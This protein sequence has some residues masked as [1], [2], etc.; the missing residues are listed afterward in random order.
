MVDIHSIRYIH[1][2]AHIMAIKGLHSPFFG[3]SPGD[4]DAKSSYIY[5]SLPKFQVTVRKLGHP[6][7]GSFLSLPATVI[8]QSSEATPGK[9]MQ[10]YQV[11]FADKKSDGCTHKSFTW[12]LLA[13]LY[14]I[15]EVFYMALCMLTS[16]LEPSE[17][18]FERPM[19]RPGP[20]FPWMRTEMRCRRPRRR[21]RKRRSRCRVSASLR[22]IAC[23]SK[24]GTGGERHLGV[25]AFFC[26]GGRGVLVSYRILYYG[27][28]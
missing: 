23:T 13:S 22:G 14:A 4:E 26:G 7:G 21:T 2:E 9:W 10:L 17:I 18:S 27:M 1:I 25:P 6:K 28:V 11:P 16:P 3:M 8:F 12:A 19:R 15:H 24:K 5:A 20:P